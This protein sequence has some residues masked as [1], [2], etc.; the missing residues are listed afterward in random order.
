MCGIAKR[1]I[2]RAEEAAKNFEHTSRL[3]D[4]LDTARAGTYIPLG[5]QSD[6]AWILR[7]EKAL[8]EG[9]MRSIV[10]AIKCL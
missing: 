5:L 7:E 3:K 10:Q 8:G 4:S 2:D 6:L 9:A 1:I